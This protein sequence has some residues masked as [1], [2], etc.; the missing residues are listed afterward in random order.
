MNS[1]TEKNVSDFSANFTLANQFGFDFS[2]DN[3]NC[4]LGLNIQSHRCYFVEL[5]KKKYSENLT[6]EKQG[7]TET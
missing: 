2:A 4:L 1:P 6:T 5:Q 3:E 7:S